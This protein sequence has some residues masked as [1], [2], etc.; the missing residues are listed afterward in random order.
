M[1]RASGDRIAVIGMACR[2]PGGADSPQRYWDL[3]REGRVAIGDIPP[4]RFDMSAILSSNPDEPG[5]TYCG[6]AGYVDAPY[7]FDAAFF[8]ISDAEALDMDPQQRWLLELCWSALEHAG[9][10]PSTLRGKRV[11]LFFTI[12]E[13]DYGRR[14]VWSG[15]AQ[16]ITAYAKLGTN[17]AVAA[18]RVAYVL[19]FQGPAV[20][21]DTA[22]SSSLVAVHMAA[23]SLRADDCDIAIA[24]GVNLILAPEE[25]IA[26]ARL[27]AMSLSGACHPFDARADGYIRGE[28]GGVVVLQRLPDALAAG[29]RVEA[30]LA[31]SAVNNDGASNGLTAP[32]GAA[33]EVVIRHALRQADIQPEEV[34]YVETHGTAT[35]LGD[36]IELGALRNVYGR[37]IGGRGR[38]LL[39][40][41]KAQIGHLEVAAGVAGLIK[42]ILVLRHR[43]VPAQP[44]FQT[45]TPRFR[46]GDAAIEVP[47]EPRP[48]TGGRP[49]VG[50]SSFGIS[51]TN[52]HVILCAAES[53]HRPARGRRTRV[54]AIS[55]A[56]AEAR[57]PLARAYREFI[58]GRDIDIADICQTA[59]LRRD[60]WAH[61]VAI[62]GDEASDF[63]DTLA[64]FEQGRASGR[65]HAAVASGPRPL[66]FLFP[67][68][69]AWRPGVGAQ[70]YERNAIFRAEV[71][72]CLA[73]L[74]RVTADDVLAAIQGIDPQRVRHHPGQLSH[75]IVLYAMARLWIR[76]GAVPSAVL[77]HSLGEHVAA[78]V[79]G[80][81]S[82]EDGLRIVEARG[83]LFDSLAP[84]GAM[85]AVA[86]NEAALAARVTLGSDLWIAA[87]NSTAQTVLSGTVQAIM[88][89]ETDMEAAGLRVSRVRAY[90]V[91]GHTP[92]LAPLREPFRDV[93]RSVSFRSPAIR[94]IST[95]TGSEATKEIGTPEHWVDLMEMPVRF[96]RAMETIASEDAILLEVGPGSGLSNL[97]RGAA[98]DRERIVSTLAD[99]PEAGQEPEATGFAHACA[100]LYC[101]G[102]PLAWDELEGESFTPAEAPTYRYAPVHLELPREKDSGRVSPPDCDRHSGPPLIRAG[103]MEDTSLSAAVLEPDATGPAQPSAGLLLAS[104]IKMAQQLGARGDAVDATIA[105]VDQG[106]DSLA[107]T[108]L[109]SRMKQLFGHAA[110]VTLFINGVSPH[111]LAEYYERTGAGR[112][113]AASAGSDKD[114]AEA[115]GPQSV[116]APAVRSKSPTDDSLVVTLREGRKPALVL[117]HPIGG[118]VLCYTDL[119]RALPGDRGIVAV[120]HPELAATGVPVYRSIGTLASLY[121][122]ALTDELGG[123][124]A[125]MAAWSLGGV[126]AQE[127]ARQWEA[128]GAA[129]PGLMLIDSP[130]AKSPYVAMVG[131]FMRTVD[132]AGTIGDDALVMQLY[133]DDRFRAVLDETFGLS[134]LGQA[135]HRAI[136]DRIGWIH[137]ASSVAL[138]KHHIGAIGGP[139]GYA[140]ALRGQNAASVEQARAH[141][142]A[143]THG[144]IDVTAFEEDHGSIMQG[145]AAAAVAAIMARNQAFASRYGVS[146]P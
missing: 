95:L 86:A 121:R 122:Q 41:V 27:R 131:E 112:D 64:D 134:R 62:V 26:S 13:V 83:R 43:L 53:T 111:G 20:F 99:G 79:A 75:F 36:P 56:R 108:E 7:H 10:P 117:V 70:L 88:R 14:T 138:A 57:Q 109:R 24:G 142:R 28:G 77:G 6:R 17:R 35:P 38:L 76:L 16:R 127:M 29:Y 139:V 91:A 32:N 12:G 92:M 116:G 11:G 48:L 85:L 105:L 9:I 5:T 59:N 93:L 104:I 132:C 143:F 87:Y 60:H 49:Y 126:V 140:L 119:V 125:D 8:R 145:T 58:A 73:R 90:D 21:I 55:A 42:A 98:A 3:I 124:P 113:G 118:D 146:A 54:L 129:V 34:A 39:G 40:A 81:T 115:G 135:A 128:E 4:G 19:G 18:G 141:L 137:V 63:V 71:D 123:L 114:A 50:V 136:A 103:V 22:C 74:D 97:A 94:L 2:L 47:I 101:L 31:G 130:F 102:I 120:R 23:Q 15:D 44:G 82:L 45:P 1:S 51:G 52:A 100:R 61:R 65:W 78:A 69:G 68:Q 96:A 106:F 46:W 84:R 80:V 133:R 144:E 67:G 66:I 33:Q 110:P 107:I 89:A 30:V 37:A 25:T 72:A